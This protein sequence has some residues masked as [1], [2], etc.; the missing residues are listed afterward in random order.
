MSDDP[1][2]TWVRDARARLARLPAVHDP[3]PRRGT[4]RG[5]RVP[6]R[7]ARAAHPPEV[8]D[9]IGRRRGDR[10]RPVQPA[11]LDRPDPRRPRHRAR[12]CAASPAPVVAVSPIVGGEVLKGPDG[13]LHG[14]RRAAS[15]SAAGVAS[16][17][18]ELLDGIVAD[19]AGRRRCR[20][21]CTDTLHGRRR[22][23]RARLAERDASRFADRALGAAS[24]CA[25]PR[26]CPS[27]ASS[28]PSS[29]SARAS[30]SALRLALAAG[31]GRRRARGARGDRPRSS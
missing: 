6:R 24:R 10:D 21:S 25:P 27:R 22:R 26:S 28:A 3:G 15:C 1:V 19:E 8:L 13:G 12:R 11:R 4:G 29:A 9:A 18:G 31:D 23:A 17:Y 5:P 2:R 30:P 14:L 20:R 16:F 7:R